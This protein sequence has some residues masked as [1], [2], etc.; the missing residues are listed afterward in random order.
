MI[1]LRV[2]VDERISPR[3]FLWPSS[4]EDQHT[5]DETTKELSDVK[6]DTFRYPRAENNQNISLEASPWSFEEI[7]YYQAVL[8]AEEARK[9]S[10]DPDPG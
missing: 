10:E 6:L 1:P 5:E 2:T 8:A 4:V 3:N 9:G 7:K